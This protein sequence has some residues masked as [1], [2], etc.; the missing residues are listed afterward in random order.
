M[1]K[2]I[3]D[4]LNNRLFTLSIHSKT[5][6]LQQRDIVA[7]AQ[8]IPKDAKSR[9]SVSKDEIAT[10]ARE[11]GLFNGW[12]VNPQ[13][14]YEDGDIVWYSQQNYMWLKIEADFRAK[15]LVLTLAEREGIA[16]RTQGDLSNISKGLAGE[17][18][19]EWE[20]QIA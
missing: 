20:K 6:E 7:I 8:K 13:L 18:M 5:I 11:V 2:A 16:I 3:Y 17:I 10:F 4:T 12:V 1:G 19:R 9:K 15:F 14:T